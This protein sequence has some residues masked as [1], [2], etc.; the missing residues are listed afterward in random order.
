M[1]KYSILLLTCFLF[2]CTKKKTVPQQKEA[3]LA[4]KHMSELATVQ[5]N[6]TKVI[7]ATDNKTWYK[8]GNRKILM[9]CEA[10]IKAGIDLQLLEA[11]DININEGKITLVLPHAQLISFNMPV[12]SIQVPYEAQG[13]FR[14]KFTNAERTE[15][16][17]QGEQQIKNKVE[18]MGVLT[19]AERNAELVIK[20]YLRKM[21]YENVTVV[22]GRKQTNNN[23]N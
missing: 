23:F 11:D 7:K 1:F 8:F 2:A 4:I 6:V 20:N 10:S 3:I 13:F 9:T 16:L 15:L 14:D 17:A 19:E 22:Y 21:G 12:D 5:Y 18:E